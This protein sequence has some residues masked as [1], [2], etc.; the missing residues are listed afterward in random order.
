[1]QMI[2]EGRDSLRAGGL[3]AQVVELLL[4][5]LDHTTIAKGIV[6]SLYSVETVDR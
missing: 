4:S 1:M 6:V 3:N 2:K 5:S